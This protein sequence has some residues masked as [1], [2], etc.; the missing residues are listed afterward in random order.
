MESESV[1]GGMLKKYNVNINYL[2]KPTV[3]GSTGTI[4]V[5]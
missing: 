3:K 4:Q 5:L 2:Q 1:G